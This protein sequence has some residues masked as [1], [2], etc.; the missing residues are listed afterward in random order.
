MEIRFKK[1]VAAIYMCCFRRGGIEEEGQRLFFRSIW[2]GLFN[3]THNGQAVWLLIYPTCYMRKEVKVPLTKG[4]F[5]QVLDTV[6]VPEM[7]RIDNNVLMEGKHYM[8][9]LEHKRKRSAS[10]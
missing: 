4:Q 10:R 1:A 6:N 9:L 7:E 2:F 8:T 3:F 5:G